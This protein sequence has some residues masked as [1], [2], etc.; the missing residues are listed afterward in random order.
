MKEWMNNILKL[1]NC[2]PRDDR[3]FCSPRFCYK[4]TPLLN[5]VFSRDQ[6]ICELK[7][8]L[9]A[10]NANTRQNVYA[11]GCPPGGGKTTLLDHIS[12]DMIRNRDEWNWENFFIV[13]LMTT[14]NSAMPGSTAFL[15]NP[16]G[17]RFFFFLISL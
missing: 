14:Y 4:S 10:Q 8:E 2:C 7:S 5:Q 3:D 1:A 16:F 12:S 15:M 17:R 13:P 6:F 11:V 9:H